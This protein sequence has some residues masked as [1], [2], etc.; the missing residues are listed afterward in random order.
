M[1]LPNMISNLND[2]LDDIRDT[3]DDKEN[4]IRQPTQVRTCFL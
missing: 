4:L 1:M 2:T 3:L